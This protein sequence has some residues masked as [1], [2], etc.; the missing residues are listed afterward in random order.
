MLLIKGFGCISALV[1][2]FTGMNKHWTQ[3]LTQLINNYWLIEVYIIGWTMNQTP[4]TTCN[5]SVYC[6]NIS[7]P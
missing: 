5:E 7:L 4:L 2:D 6:A 3:C 1:L